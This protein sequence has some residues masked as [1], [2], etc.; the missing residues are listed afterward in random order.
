[1]SGG[2][3]SVQAAELLVMWDNHILHLPD[4]T[5]NGAD[6][7]GLV[8]QVFLLGE[9][10]KMAFVLAEGKIVIEMFDETPR[11]G[12]P[13]PVRLGGW[14]FDK[15]VLRS[16]K[17]VDERFGKCYAL[18]LPWPDYRPDITQVKLKARYEP[19]HGY[20]LFAP[21]TSLV[22]DTSPVQGGP[23]WSHQT[24]PVTAVP[25][26]I[27]PQGS[28]LGGALPVNPPGAPS[29]FGPAPFGTAPPPGVGFNQ[30]PAGGFSQP[31]TGFGPQSGAPR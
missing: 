19:E 21:D 5:K 15:E 10:P 18:F 17:V 13:A 24:L 6:I 4:P 29:G 31:M 20:K 8:G 3:S 12:N 26:S 30:P 22:L 2:S 1:M 7:G 16:H 11:P 9:A 14:T 25:P 27:I 28:G 23:T